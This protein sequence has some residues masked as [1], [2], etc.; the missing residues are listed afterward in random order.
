MFDLLLHIGIE[1]FIGDGLL[2]DKIFFSTY[3]K[4]Y[5]FIEITDFSTV[6]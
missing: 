5:S 3:E 4:L 2:D 1:N 6:G